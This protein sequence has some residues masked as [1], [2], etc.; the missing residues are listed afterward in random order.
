MTNLDSVNPGIT[1]GSAPVVGE[2]IGPYR[3]IRQ[4]GQGTTSRVFEVEHTRIGRRAAMKVVHRIGVPPAVVDRL[5]MEAQAV[6]LINHPHVVEISDILL[7][8]ADQPDHALVMELLEGRSLADVLA[9][10]GPLPAARTLP[11]MAQ[12]CAGLAAVHRA[13]FVHRDLKPEN[14]FLIE[15]GGDRDF[16]KL[17]DF[18]LVKALR[19]DVGAGTATV[20]GT[21]MGSPAYAS[22]EQSAGKPVDQRSDIYAVGVMLHELVTGRLPFVCEHIADLLMK[23]ITAPPP[24]LPDELLAT[25]IGRA[26]DAIIQACLVKEPAERVLSAAQLGDM[27]GRLAA[28]D[29]AIPDGIGRPRRLR[30]MRAGRRGRAIA[31][32]LALAAVSFLAIFAVRQTRAITPLPAAPTFP[33]PLVPGGPA[34]IAETTKPPPAPSADPQ[35]VRPTAPRPRRAARTPQPRVSKAMTLDPYR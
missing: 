6:N 12:I 33:A 29:H 15:R 28:G 18:G 19:G 26:M 34:P 20:E 5:F 7:P 16:V 2:T 32:A 4:L 31:P 25:D 3:I 35:H 17:L 30:W 10:D 8:A 24:R 23:Q 22:P 13:G 27:F 21:F 14:V 1:R 11:I 9:K